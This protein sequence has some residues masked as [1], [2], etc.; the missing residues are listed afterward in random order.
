MSRRG[1][2]WHLL[3]G[4][5]LGS[6]SIAGCTV[7]PDYVRP[8]AAVPVSFKEQSAPLHHGWKSATPLDLL[9]RGPWWEIYKDPA[10]S[11]LASQVEL[12]NQTVAAAVAAYQQAREVIREG[13]AG[14]FPTVTNSYS[15]TG[16]HSGA[17]LS[18]TGRATTAL[19]FNPVANATWDLD[20]WGRIRRTVESDAAAAQVS[21]ADLQNAKLSAQAALATAYFELKATDALKKLYERTAVEYKHTLDIVTNQYNGGTA[22]RADVDAAQTELLAVEAQAINTGINRSQ[23][24]HAIA[25]LIGRPPAALTIPVNGRFATSVP[26]VPAGMPS[27]LLERRPDIAA[28][29]RTLQQ[30]NALIGVAV[31]NFYPDINLSGAFG[32]AGASPLPVSAAAEMW[33]LAGTATQTVF[34][35]GLRG[36][37][38]GAARASYHQSVATYRQ[39][40]LT[41]FQQVE[42]ELAAL[43]ILAQEAQKDREAIKAAREAVDVYFNQYRAGTVAFTTVVTAQATLLA[44]EETLL[45]VEENQLIASVAL[46]EALGGG[47]NSDQLPGLANLAAVTT[48]TPPL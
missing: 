1:V 18:N 4:A 29:E 22:S 39:T 36:A 11:T 17:G 30:E 24:E 7:G 20:V 46:I 44:N 3:L 10:L 15:A 40:V 26:P 35:G 2:S 16:S 21:A 43:R 19:S 42:D 23:Y 6:L 9:D 47:W 27:R 38:L 34:D 8:D 13:Q 48:I 31:A 5:A 14:L 41:A 45:A 37:E 33:S 25:V 32:F 12:S 28:A